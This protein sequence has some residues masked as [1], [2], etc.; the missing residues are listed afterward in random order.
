MRKFLLSFF[1]LASI[2]ASAQSFTTDGFTY[3]VTSPTTVEL[4]SGD[5]KL[6][7]VDIPETVKNGEVTYTIKSIGEGAFKWGDLTKL[8]LPASVDSVKKSAFSSTH[9]AEVNFKEGLKYIGDYAFYGIKITSVTLPN[10]LI[11]LGTDAFAASTS[12]ATVNLSEGLKAIGKSAFYH[13]AITSITIPSSCDSLLTT[14]FLNCDKLETVNL[15]DNVVFMGDGVFNGCK[16]LKAITLPASLNTIGVEPFLGCKNLTSINIPAALSS[17]DEAFI[18][19]TGITNITVDA[20]NKRFHVVDGVLYSI[21]NKLLCAA[22][23]KGLATI[24]INSACLGILGGAFWGSEIEKVTF[25]DG[26]AYIGDY[27]FCQSKLSTVNF[28][29]TLTYYGEQAFA[30]TNLT[31]VTLPENAPYIQDGAF[32]Y[33][34]NLASVTIPSS[35]KQ[36]YAHAFSGDAG[37]KSFTCLGSKAP[38]IMSYYEVEDNPFYGIDSSIPVN[39]L[40]NSKQSFVDN[41]WGDFFTITEGSVSIFPYVSS[42]P[43]DSSVIATNNKY[44]AMSFDIVFDKPITI[45]KQNPDVFLREKSVINPDLIT[46][47][48]QWNAVVGK[49][50][51]TLNIWGADYDGYTCSFMPNAN[52]EYYLVI[53]A[54]TVK[55]DAGDLNEQIVIMFYGSTPTGVDNVSFND[56]ANSNATVVARY[57]LNGQKINGAQ[58][59]I[60]IVKMSDGSTKK[61][62]VE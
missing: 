41:G 49:D 2:T 26:F 8:T 24:K 20:N 42:N 14:A 30:G 61:I 5:K 6:T 32:A 53:P 25:P 39:V 1:A 58:K 21:D 46:P 18:S 7:T 44:A 50:K 19:Q 52:E 43:A 9:L 57:N 36:I 10:T 16:L 56:A 37:I 55:N 31:D 3:T 4:T 40:K 13:T 22:P 28:P 35:V 54:G 51:N 27:A 62:I 12:L 59:G 11:K 17:I 48:N 45:V 29:K 38:E 23:M 47:D 34:P 33:C 15:S 60:N